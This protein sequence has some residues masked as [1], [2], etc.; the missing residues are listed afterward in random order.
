VEA[1][2]LETPEIPR[3]SG[4][5]LRA[6]RPS[7]RRRRERADAAAGP[8]I[9]APPGCIVDVPGRGEFFIRDTGGDGP[10]VLLLHGWMVSADLNW[11]RAYDPLADAGYRVLAIDHRGH[12]RGL[13]SHAP[14]RLADCADD[15]A[16]VI[17][18]LG[19]GPVTAVGYSM[20][21]PITQLLARRHPHVLRSIVLCATSREWQ[22]PAFQRLWRTMWLLRLTVALAP[23]GFATAMLRASGVPEDASTAWFTAEL[24][25]GDAAA[26]AE[27][28]RELGRFD[29]RLWLGELKVP[30]AVVVTANDRSVPPS[31][32]R[33]LAE[34]LGA[35]TFEVAGD[36]FVVG[37]ADGPFNAGLLAA[38]ERLADGA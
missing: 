7:R 17:E 30:A 1:A 31:M 34:Q 5:A 12:G 24:S 27:A 22:A 36:H 3:A 37:L 11:L 38:L 26:M 14:F 4:L 25:R 33:A 16:A 20:G 29:S 2:S 35:P 15:A 23:V 6:L 9:A 13:R 19:V 21:G 18:A 10:A 32:Q 8:P 28:G